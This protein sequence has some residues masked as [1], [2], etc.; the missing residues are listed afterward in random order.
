MSNSHGDLFT[1]IGKLVLAANSGQ[2]ID[3]DTTVK[4]L[5]ERYRNLGMTE[6]TLMKVVSRSIGAISYSMARSNGGLQSRLEALRESG[7]GGEPIEAAHIE[8]P[9][10]ADAPA[11]ANGKEAPIVAKQEAVAVTPQPAATA[12]SG[13]RSRRGSA[14]AAPTADAGGSKAKSV[15]PSGVR[16]AVLS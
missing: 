11:A 13:R 8:E 14:K 9:R 15:F 5:S 2:P 10:N 16:L 6:E 7:M 12:N 1:E 4:D 3:L